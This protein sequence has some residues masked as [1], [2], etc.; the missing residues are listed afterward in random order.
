LAH[1]EQIKRGDPLPPALSKADD[2]DE[3]ADE[4][5]FVILSNRKKRKTKEK[6]EKQ[7]EKKRKI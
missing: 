7:K 1:I 3:A 2:G 4:P 5:F 6:E